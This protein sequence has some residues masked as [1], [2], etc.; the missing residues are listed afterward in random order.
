MSLLLKYLHKNQ[1]PVLLLEFLPEANA[2]MLETIIRAVQSF[3]HLYW[4]AHR[5][6]RTNWFHLQHIEVVPAANEA[7]VA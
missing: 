4:Y 3:V 1:Y 5:P 7:L 6:S 2:V